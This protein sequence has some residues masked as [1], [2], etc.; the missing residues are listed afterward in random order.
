[1]PVMSTH[2]DQRLKDSPAKGQ[3]SESRIVT[4]E[5][6]EQ[7]LRTNNEQTNIGNHVGQPTNASEA[8]LPAFY[9]ATTVNSGLPPMPFPYM[10]TGMADTWS[11]NSASLF[12]NTN[13]AFPSMPDQML[14]QNPAVANAGYLN[15]L[16]GHVPNTGLPNNIAYLNQQAL[17]FPGNTTDLS[18]GGQQQ[19]SS[20][21][22]LGDFYQQPANIAVH[23]NNGQETVENKGVEHSLAGL[24][25]Q[26]DEAKV[27]GEAKQ[28]G[29]MNTPAP[30]NSGPPKPKSWAAIA[31]QPAKPKP[32]APK[33]KPAAPPMNSGNRDTNSWNGTNSSVKSGAKAGGTRGSGQ[34]RNRSGGNAGL[35]NI[36]APSQPVVPVLARL[37]SINDYNPKDFNLRLKDVRFFIIKSYSED[38]I[39]RSIK[40]SVWTSTE[41]G[42][43][44]LNDAFKEQQKKGPM[45]MLFSVNGSGHF[46]GIA[47][48]KSEVEYD[49]ETGI[50]SQ[51]KWKGKFAVKWHYVKDV[52]NN[53]LR[54]IRL[55]NNDNKPVTNSRDTQE[56]PPE[57]GVQVVKIIHS[58]KN[59]TSIFDDF[60][61]YEKRQEEEIKSKGKKLVGVEA[62]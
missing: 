58:Y 38:D 53:A 36:S 56:V 14:Q 7:Y 6:F 20:G 61:H 59:Q 30:S 16:D 42:N 44:R 18:W 31:S 62:P 28:N 3:E 33:V 26:Q 60:G 24:S 50:W 8:Y 45:Y 41:H 57:K 2:V 39:H 37:R 5:D 52:P 15:G 55:E 11:T 13:G 48:M 34:Q 19:T 23:E 43:R 32:P 1:M 40:Y 21:S 9:A 17:F 12:P 49:I 29:D 22:I 47:E 46:C 4:D 27:N 25:L 10:S 35:S 54:H 51:E